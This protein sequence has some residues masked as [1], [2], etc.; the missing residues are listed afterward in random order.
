[1]IS[2]IATSKLIIEG[3]IKCPVW[4]SV[5]I[6][7]TNVKII[8]R[9][10]KATTKFFTSIKGIKLLNFKSLSIEYLY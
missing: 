2:K 9:I 4:F 3:I 8:T 10:K 6:K 7:L 5:G 1:M